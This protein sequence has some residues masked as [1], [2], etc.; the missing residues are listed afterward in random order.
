M[1]GRELRDLRVEAGLTQRDLAR[2]C[3]VS[4]SSLRRMENGY[5]KVTTKVE[6]HAKNERRRLLTSNLLAGF[7][8]KQPLDTF[9]RLVEA[10]LI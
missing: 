7:V 10:P 3:G 8:P 5:E 2:I 6:W 1:T 9:L 4:Q